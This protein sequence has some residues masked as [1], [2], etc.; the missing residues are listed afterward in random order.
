VREEY[1]MN[2]V[3]C[4]IPFVRRIEEF[5][6]AKKIMEE[7]GLVRGPDFKL[8]IMVEVPN[9]VLLI[10]KF[11]QEGFDGVSFGTND[12]T[13]LILGIDRDD[14]S[15]AEIYDERNLGVLRAIAHVI[16]ECNKHGVTT[17]I[18]G[19]APSNYPEYLEFMVRHGATS[20]SVNP[21]VVVKTRGLVA[22][23]ERKMLLDQTIKREEKTGTII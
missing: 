13:M 8:W 23:I 5:R 7:E 2:N 11:I 6:E 12:L 17:S 4:M 15:V 10:D 18:C 1:K 22:H 16:D 9:T 21:D 14:A 3:Y 20:V 19:Q